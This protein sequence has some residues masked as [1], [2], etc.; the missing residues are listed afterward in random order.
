MAG[1]DGTSKTSI[2][3]DTLSGASREVS[4][5]NDNENEQRPALPPRPITLQPPPRPSSPQ[6]PV[7]R[8]TSTKRPQLQSQPTTALSSVDVQ[9][10]SFPDGSRG[11]FPI[12]NDNLNATSVSGSRKVGQK[13]SEVDDSASLTSYNPSLR[14][15]GDLE[16]LLGNGF[17]TQSPAWK[18]LNSQTD[19]GTAFDTIEFDED[20][21][22]SAFEHEFDEVAEVDSKHGNEG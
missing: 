10:L 22:L 4:P 7:S 14:V 13:S 18:L 1:E 11:T 12:S 6:S 15:A 21:Q 9:T 19:P 2:Q 8:T 17:N 3:T 20:D 16:S 5:H